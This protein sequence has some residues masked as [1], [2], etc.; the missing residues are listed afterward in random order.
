M[1]PWPRHGVHGEDD[2][3]SVRHGGAGHGDGEGVHHEC[4]FENNMIRPLKFVIYHRLETKGSDEAA[5][6]LM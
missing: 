3:A 2:T 1:R 4:F 5:E 6:P